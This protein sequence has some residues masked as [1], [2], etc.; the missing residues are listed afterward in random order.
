MTTEY[1]FGGDSE[2]ERLAILARVTAPSTRN[3]LAR[4][5]VASEMRCLDVGCGTGA[6]TR[7]IA[8]LVGPAGLVIGIDRD[9]NAIELARSV[10]DGYPM[11]E[12]RVGLLAELPQQPEYDVVYARFLLTHSTLR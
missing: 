2:K 4:A 7:E 1:V 5:G 12:F 6:I 10:T 3:L 8:T 9:P 11:I